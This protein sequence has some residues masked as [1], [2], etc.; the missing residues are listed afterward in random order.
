MCLCARTSE[1]N[2]VYKKG[3]IRCVFYFF[4][5]ILSQSCCVLYT[6]EIDRQFNFVDV[7]L[8]ARALF[9][10][11]T[12]LW[13]KCT[14]S[15]SEHWI[16]KGTNMLE[17]NFCFIYFAIA[18]LAFAA[19]DEIYLSKSNAV[20]SR[21]IWEKRNKTRGEHILHSIFCHIFRAFHRILSIYGQRFDTQLFVYE[22]L[23]L[24]F[25]RRCYSIC[26]SNTKINARAMTT[27]WITKKTESR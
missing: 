3:D 13:L 23:I 20:E 15:I 24:A 12:V 1:R 26:W 19:D 14:R 10:R 11:L 27:E 5:Y 6:H 2:F 17:K 21:M 4:G 22:F 8:N 16:K 7:W 18:C 9:W 25:F